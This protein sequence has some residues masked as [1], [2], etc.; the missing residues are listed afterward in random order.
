MN[1]T[2]KLLRAFIEAQGFEIE[3]VINKRALVKVGELDTTPYPDYITTIDYKVTKKADDGIV[4]GESKYKGNLM[5]VEVIGSR[6]A[7]ERLSEVTA[8]MGQQ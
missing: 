1:N 6:T 7:E 3:E 5:K 2:D 8:R 4:L